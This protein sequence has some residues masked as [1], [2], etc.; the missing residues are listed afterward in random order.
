M[1]SNLIPLNVQNA[2]MGR[3]GMPAS[4]PARAPLARP[5]M[6]I[7]A[8]QPGMAEMQ[9]QPAA[10]PQS[11]AVPSAV[12]PVMP[13]QPIMRPAVM[14]GQI[15]NVGTP[16]PAN[17]LGNPSVQDFLRRRAGVFF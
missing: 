4:V 7:N 14:P 16:G 2:A 9:P 3:A 10:A 6:N 15:P 5:V 1:M 17:L 12:S 8:A 13:A 11:M